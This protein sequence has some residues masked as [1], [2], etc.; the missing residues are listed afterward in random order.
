MTQSL[1]S[2][3]LS[4]PL[5]IEFEITGRCQ[6]NC[7]YC[8]A[9]PLGQP[10]VPT[11]RAL[12]LIDEMRQIGVLSLLLSGGEP[13]LHRS[14]LEIASAASHSV[15]QLVVNTNG[16]RLSR[17]GFCEQLN[18]VA[19]RALV[20]ISLDSADTA[21]N[22]HERGTGGGQAIAAIENCVALGQPVCIS[23][24][25]TEASME[26]ASNLIRRFAPR[27]RV[28]RFFPRVPRSDDDL[29]RNDAAYVQSTQAFYDRLCTLAVENP[30]LDLLTPSGNARDWRSANKGLST[31]ECV[32]SQTRLFISR[33]LNV[34]PCYYSANF[35]SLLGS[36]EHHL[37]S[38][39]WNS[40]ARKVVLER[41]RRERLCGFTRGPQSIPSRYLVT[42]GVQAISIIAAQ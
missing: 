12:S 38:H 6:L 20:A 42:K 29:I 34:Y 2:H 32:C 17:F 24:V 33:S 15:S 1:T 13:T 22:D 35:D 4:A 37:L 19:P 36:C 5:H 23:A 14:F 41:S 26:T 27:V 3:D 8:S 18:K 39:L 31:A 10:D 16:I 7:S 9:A 40:D 28:F 21:V 11:R 30:N 25:L